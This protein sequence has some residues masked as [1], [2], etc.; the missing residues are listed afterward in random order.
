M[1]N[2]RKWGRGSFVM[3]ALAIGCGG[4][5]DDGGVGAVAQALAPAGSDAQVLNAAVPGAL[6]PGERRFASVTMLNTGASSPANDWTPPTYAL[7][8]VNSNFNWTNAFVPAAVPVGAQHTFSF[9]IT[10][11]PA[12]QPFLAR[13][14]A[15]GNDYFGEVVSVPVTVSTSVTPEW[16]CTLVSSTL[17]AHLS[18]GESYFATVTVQNTGSETWPAQNMKLASRDVPANL[19]G[20]THADLTTAVAPGDT[21]TF[22]FNLKAPGTA[23][24]YTF[25]R[26]MK[27]YAGIGDFRAWGLCVEQQIQVGGI[28]PRDSHVLSIEFPST[29]GASTPATLKVTLQN[30]GTETWTD[31]GSF[32][33][34]SLNDPVNAWGATL[35]PLTAATPPG[36]SGVFVA[37]LT[38]PS[39]PGT[40]ALRWQVRKIAGQGSGFF[41]DVVEVPVTVTP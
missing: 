27:N 8:G 30:A 23:G 1:R 29:L 37:G 16:G 9:V 6:F 3:A 19:W 12:S 7:R 33:L 38:A 28:P 32:V 10:A 25:L 22:G 41:G 14:T 36:G 13:M 35:A 39:T 5:G 31:D 18:P 4:Q 40:Y 20:A 34:Y 21:A 26:D 17:P 15:S 24:T 2:S 11:P